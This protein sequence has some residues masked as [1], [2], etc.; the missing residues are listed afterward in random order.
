MSKLFDGERGVDVNDMGHQA[1]MLRTLG[2]AL[3]IRSCSSKVS[4]VRPCFIATFGCT[5]YQTLEPVRS[6]LSNLYVVSSAPPGN[7]RR[8]RIPAARNA[9]GYMRGLRYRRI[10]LLCCLMSPNEQD[11]E[12]EWPS[13]VRE[14]FKIW[15]GAYSQYNVFLRASLP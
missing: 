15:A 12:A 3:E 10:T 6:H 7:K 9:P 4:G 8:R 14:A 13:A 5:L 11:E 1:K 2:V